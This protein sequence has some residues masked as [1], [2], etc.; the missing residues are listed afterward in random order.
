MKIGELVGS[1]NKKLDT[2]TFPL[3]FIPKQQAIPFFSSRREQEIYILVGLNQ[4]LWNKRHQ[5][6]FKELG[7]K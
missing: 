2:F 1:L 7:R 3:L 6:Q 4:R 5:A